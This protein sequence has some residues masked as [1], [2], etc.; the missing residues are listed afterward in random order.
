[1]LSAQVLSPKLA[2]SM[3]AGALGME[4]IS[5]VKSPTSSCRLNGVLFVELD[6]IRD[7]IAFRRYDAFDDQPFSGAVFS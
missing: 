3:K 2:S 5:S 6:A 7:F 4:I 1:M